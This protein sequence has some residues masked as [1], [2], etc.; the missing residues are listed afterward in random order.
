MAI[1]CQAQRT[2]QTEI[3]IIG[4]VHDSL[5]NYNPQIL[6][7]ILEKI[8]PDIILH[9]VDA[10]G[11]QEYNR[12]STLT[13][14]ELLASN[15]YLA[16]HPA[17]LRF[18]FDFEGRN[19]YRKT[20]GMVPVDNLSVQLI[21]SLHQKGMLSQQEEKTY[22]DFLD[23]TN[24]LMA[25][26]KLS[27]EHFNNTTTD[28]LAKRRQELQYQGLSAITSRRPEFEL[29]T[30]VKP[31]GKPIT[32]REGFRLMS[33]FWDVRNQTMAKNIIRIAKEHK[34]TKIVVLTGFLHRYY[35]ISELTKLNQGSYT[36]KA[37]PVLRH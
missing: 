12:D 37:I 13:G 19:E 8:G 1:L 25:I 16:K 9:E 32:Y 30:F 20:L 18:P 11:M 21:D 5:P 7:E 24:K 31:D 4:N 23:A 3:Y 15:R 28:S 26:A 10:Q 29:H 2:S 36:L 35:L 14:N 17:T 33:G 6:Y 22:L 27:P 34:H